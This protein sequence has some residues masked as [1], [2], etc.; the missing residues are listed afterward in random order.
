MK[1]WSVALILCLNI[2]VDPPDVVKTNPCARRECWIGRTSTHLT[3]AH[4]RPHTH[5][6]SLSTSSQKALEEIGNSLQKQYERWQPRAR[7]KQ[8][9]DPTTEEVR[10]LCMALRK[11]AKVC[12]WCLCDVCDMCTTLCRVNACSSITMAMGYP[13]QLRTERYGSSIK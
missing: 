9:L 6:D 4:I 3:H 13:N 7:C 12:G 2:G 10:K 1:T 11:N 8:L 5:T